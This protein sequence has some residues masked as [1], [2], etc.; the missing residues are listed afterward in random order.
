MTGD[1]SHSEL[2]PVDELAEQFLRRRRRG[3]H[4]TVAEYAGL[5]RTR[6]ADS[7]ALSGPRADR[8]AQAHGR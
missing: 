1:V 8:A 7:R 5:P 4:P 2:D 3:E 6:S